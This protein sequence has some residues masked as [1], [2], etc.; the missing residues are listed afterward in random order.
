MPII[1]PG[2]QRTSGTVIRYHKTKYKV[3]RLQ[4]EGKYQRQSGE[5]KPMTGG[6]LAVLEA[7]LAEIEKRKHLKSLN[8]NH[9]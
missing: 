4:L 2:K 7:R 3:T 6:S 1:T 9:P 5:E 8:E